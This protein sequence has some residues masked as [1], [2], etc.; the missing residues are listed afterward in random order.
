MVVVGQDQVGSISNIDLGTAKLQH[1][2]QSELTT[3]NINH[4]SI[5]HWVK[6]ISL[7]SRRLIFLL[8][9][10]NEATQTFFCL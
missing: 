7:N 4:K 2:H 1:Q 8:L 5:E 3:A 6:H 9:E 10:K